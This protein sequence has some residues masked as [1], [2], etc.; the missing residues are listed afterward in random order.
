ML[1]KKEIIEVLVDYGLSII[2][3]DRVTDNKKNFELAIKDIIEK[4]QSDLNFF[5]NV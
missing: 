5:E 3:S 1:K 4:S 2:E